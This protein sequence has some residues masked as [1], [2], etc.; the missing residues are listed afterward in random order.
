MLGAP[1][2]TPETVLETLNTMGRIASKWDL[3]FVSTGLRVYNGAPIADEIM[4]HDNH[5]TADNFLHPVKIEPAKISLAEIHKIAKHFSF[6]FPNF[7]LY[8][9]EHIIPGWLLIIGNALLKVFHSNQ[10]VWRL[11]ILLKMIERALGIG[12]VK[13]NLYDLKLSSSDKNSRN[14]NGFSI[15]GE[16]KITVKSELK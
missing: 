1:A 9:K 14:S 5:C 16:R 10:P 7:Y 6:R 3:V 4:K 2:E 8:E 12:L 15:I 11:L 13:R